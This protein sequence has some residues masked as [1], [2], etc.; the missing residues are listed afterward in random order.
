MIE[1]YFD[2]IEKALINDP[3]V[4]LTNIN[5]Y[6]TNPKTA[7]IRVKALFIDGSSLNIFQHIHLKKN[8][9][10]ITDYRLHYMDSES[11]LIFRYDNAPHYPEISTFPNH[12]HIPSGVREASIPNIKELLNEIHKHIVREITTS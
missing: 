8:N 10:I 12:K 1:N 4:V 2:E 11:K 3:L 6:H 9:I 5:R 7:Y